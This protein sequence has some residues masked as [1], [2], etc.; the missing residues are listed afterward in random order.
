M[1]ERERNSKASKPRR[2]LISAS[3]IVRSFF[4]CFLFRMFI[5]M[6]LI[7]FIYFVLFASMIVIVVVVAVDVAMVVTVFLLSSSMVN[8]HLQI[9][10]TNILAH[11]FA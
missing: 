2:V 9:N 3:A 6:G 1:R 5:C 10:K 11:F 8:S 7:V 4:V